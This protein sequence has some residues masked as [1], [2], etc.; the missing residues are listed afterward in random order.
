MPDQAEKLRRMVAEEAPNVPLSA[1]APPMIA[2]TGGKGGVGTTTVA[3]NLAAALA[4][5]GRRVVLV[6][7]ARHHADLTEL[8]GIHVCGGGTLSDVLAGKTSAAEALA[9]GPAGTLLLADR[10]GARPH[11][12]FSSTAQQRLLAELDALGHLADVLVIDTGSGAS[13]WAQQ[14]WQHARLIIVIAACD[15]V[16]VMDAYATIKLGTVT[17]SD[18][19]VRVLVNQSRRDGDATEVGRRLALACRRFLGRTVPALPALP[20]HAADEV[21]ASED[22]APRVWEVPSTPFGHA[23]L[24]LGS[25]VRDLLAPCATACSETNGGMSE[26][27]TAAR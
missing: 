26:A 3:M 11:S 23:V 10:W 7:A 15:D 5:G 6:D 2:V 24:W 19:E 20:L 12:N 9:P 18:A 22:S 21:G 25:A 13:Q 4:D 16:A 1:P 14:F 17:A 8:A 27:R